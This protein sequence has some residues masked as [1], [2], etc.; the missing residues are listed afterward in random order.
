[1]KFIIKLMV[2]TLAVMAGL[3]VS[4]G[5][6]SIINNVSVSASSGGNSA[7]GGDTV[8][9]GKSRAAISVKTVVNGQEVENI[10]DQYTASSSDVNIE[11]QTNYNQGGVQSETEIRANVENRNSTTSTRSSEEASVFPKTVDGISTRT[12]ALIKYSDS[13]FPNPLRDT[14]IASLPKI[15]YSSVLTPLNVKIANELPASKPGFVSKFVS[16]IK[17]FMNY[18]LSVI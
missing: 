5:S 17:S 9:T 10:S 8:S 4:A 12:A 14:R 13:L 6:V 18:V 2:T 11:K 7:G 1:M 15:N 3:N 16:G